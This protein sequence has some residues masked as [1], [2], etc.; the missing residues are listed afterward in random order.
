V[1]LART[2]GLAGG[3]DRVVGL[4]DVA[5]RDLVGVGRDRVAVGRDLVGVAVGRDRVVDP[6]GRD[7]VRV[8]GRVAGVDRLGG[9]TT[10]PRV[11]DRAGCRVRVD[12]PPD[13]LARVDVDEDGLDRTVVE[14]VPAAF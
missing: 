9:L 4:L 1:G 8:D 12:V 14:R 11:V 5:G 13:G 7:R 2:L 10:V 6:V 3:D